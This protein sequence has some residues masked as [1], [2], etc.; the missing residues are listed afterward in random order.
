ML[1]SLGLEWKLIFSSP[2]ATAEFLKFAGV[3]AGIPSPP[4]TLFIVML[5]KAHLTS[6]S[7]MPGSK[8]VITP[9]C[10]SGSL[11]YFL[12]SSYVYSCHLFLIS[13]ASVRSITFQSLFGHLCMKCSLGIT[14]F[15]E[16]I[17]IIYHSTV[18]LYCF[19]LITEEGFLMSPCSSLELW[20]QMGLAFLFSNAFIFS[21]FLR[22]F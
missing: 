5:P 13:C 12:Y 21:S 4:V 15:L 2:V 22:Y 9:S 14:N 18:F 7:R 19:A 1:P 11:R 6:D 20:F 10:L 3:S 16:E 8:W 17:F